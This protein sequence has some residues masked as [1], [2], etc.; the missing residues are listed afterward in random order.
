METL[1]KQ[2]DK[3]VKRKRAARMMG[4]WGARSNMCWQD[5]GYDEDDVNEIVASIKMAVDQG[6]SMMLRD[7][8]KPSYTTDDTKQL[9]VVKWN[10]FTPKIPK[11]TVDAHVT[12]H[13]IGIGSESIISRKKPTEPKPYVPPAKRYT[14]REDCD[15][16]ERWIGI[17]EQVDNMNIIRTPQSVQNIA[18]WIRQ[19]EH[20][21][22]RCKQPVSCEQVREILK[23]FER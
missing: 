9:K 20:A 1:S 16:V 2:K 18:T 4:I 5:D 12:S 10:G 11:V 14:L 21:N 23:E 6:T 13:V 17:I 3:D 19:D 8:I 15:A 7:C 22:Y